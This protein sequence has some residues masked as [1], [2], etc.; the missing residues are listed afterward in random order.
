MIITTVQIAINNPNNNTNNN[1][2]H[3]HN[4]NNHNN[5][6]NTIPTT[7]TTT[8]EEVV[9][10]YAAEVLSALEYLHMKGFVYRGTLIVSCVE[11]L[12]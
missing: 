7:T 5:H 8:T 10:F 12:Q 11:Q 3:N 6:N 9:K 1:H 2:N 4:H